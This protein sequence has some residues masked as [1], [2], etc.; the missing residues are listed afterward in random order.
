MTPPSLPIDKFKY[1]DENYIKCWELYNSAFDYINEKENPK[2]YVKF[3]ENARLLN[4]ATTF[5]DEYDNRRFKIRM[6]KTKNL[7]PKRTYAQVVST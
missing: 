5:I 3:A 4:I 6:D 1:N 2:D 7:E